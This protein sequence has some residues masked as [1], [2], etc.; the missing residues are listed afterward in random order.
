[1]GAADLQGAVQQHDAAAGS[2]GCR[3]KGAAA[4]HPPKLPASGRGDHG[5]VLGPEP[6]PEVC[7]PEGLGVWVLG[8][9]FRVGF[10]VLG[11]WVL[12]FWVFG[13]RV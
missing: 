2:S 1:M 8:L 3:T 12:G 4:R 6:C 9:G 7:K 11:V 13:V 10:W 5:G